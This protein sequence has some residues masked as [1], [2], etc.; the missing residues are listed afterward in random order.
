M[1]LANPIPVPERV[2]YFLLIAPVIGMI[3]VSWVWANQL[4]DVRSRVRE[5]DLAKQ[6][7]VKMMIEAKALK[8]ED[9]PALP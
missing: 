7:L 1:A 2:F 4:T 3:G 6:E 9:I 8:P 5:E